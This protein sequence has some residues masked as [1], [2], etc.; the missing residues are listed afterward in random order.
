MSVIRSFIFFNIKYEYNITLKKQIEPFGIHVSSCSNVDIVLFELYLTS[1][2]FQCFN[3]EELISFL[4]ISLIKTSWVLIFN[5]NPPCTEIMNSVS[6]TKKKFLSRQ[7]SLSYGMLIRCCLFRA[8]DY[9]SYKT[10]LFGICLVD[11]MVYCCME[12]KAVSLV[13]HVDV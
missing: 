8:L 7:R 13:V 5:S 10:N 6:H 3:F 12:E 2:I 1:D 9:I 4:H 11:S